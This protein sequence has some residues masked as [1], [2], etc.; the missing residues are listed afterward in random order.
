[1]E[2]ELVDDGKIT[3]TFCDTPYTVRYYVYDCNPKRFEV[4][5]T[6][7]RREPAFFGL[8][9]GYKRLNKKRTFVEKGDEHS[10]DEYVEAMVG[11]LFEQ[12]MSREEARE[13]SVTVE[14]E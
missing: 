10:V 8:T 3:E 2:K 11:K 1:M 5:A 12:A 6:L 4:V 7:S 13:L 9:Y 14:V